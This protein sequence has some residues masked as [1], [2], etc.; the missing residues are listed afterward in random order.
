VSP[1]GRRTGFDECGVSRASWMSRWR[2][3][4]ATS[5]CDAHVAKHPCGMQD[6]TRSV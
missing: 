5:P 1:S 4:L 3:V 6:A 2:I